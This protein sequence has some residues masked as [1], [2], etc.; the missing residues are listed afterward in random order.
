[1]SDLVGLLANIPQV[2]DWEPPSQERATTIIASSSPQ[3]ALDAHT[4]MCYL[5]GGFFSADGAHDVHS[6]LDR[7]GEPLIP[8][9]EDG[10]KLKTPTELLKYQDLTLQG[11]E[12]EREYSDYWNSTEELDGKI[13]TLTVSSQK[14]IFLGQIVDAVLMPVAPHAAVIP[15]KYYHGGRYSTLLLDDVLLTG[16]TA[17][18]DAMNVTNYSVVVIPTI[19]ADAKIDFFDDSYKPLGDLDIKNWKSCKS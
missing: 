15:G 19:R 8:D 17:Y 4:Y 13:L 16:I 3:L 1:M 9:L 6:H 14:L 12:Y 10:F 11:L 7:S 18:T 5:Q 2:V